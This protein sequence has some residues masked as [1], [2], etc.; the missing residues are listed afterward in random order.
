MNI[1]LCLPG[2]G[3]K[4]AFQAGVICSLYDNKINKF[5]IVTGTSIG[6][7]NGYFVYTDNVDKLKDMW[8]NLDEKSFVNGKI[9]DNVVDNSEI[10]NVLKDLKDKGDNTRSLYV[11]YTKIRNHSIKEVT[12]DVS[13]QDV[14][15]GLDYIKYSSLLPCKIDE[16]VTL[17]ELMDS[18]DVGKVFEDFRT[19]VINGVFDGYDLDGGIIRNTLLTPF[20]EEKVDKLIIIP[21]RND[22]TAPDYIKDHYNDEDIIIIKPNTK[23]TSEHTLKFEREFCREIFNEGYELAKDIIYKLE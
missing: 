21:M 7:I 1:G 10:I 2:G 18:Y 11:N 13:K 3:A 5:S 17:K 15:K 6:A 20:I 16:E 8:T 14:E 23:L 22:Y 12:V 9:K 19:D 4:G